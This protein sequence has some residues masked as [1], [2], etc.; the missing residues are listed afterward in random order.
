MR[1]TRPDVR[2][3]A[4]RVDDLPAGNA[5]MESAVRLGDVANS[6]LLAVSIVMS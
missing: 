1:E 5:A 3:S 2:L 4:V 6:N